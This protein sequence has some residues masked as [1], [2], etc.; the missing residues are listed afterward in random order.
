MPLHFV[1]LKTP[2]KLLL[3]TFSTFSYLFLEKKKNFFFL[4]YLFL[5]V[6]AGNLSKLIFMQ[7]L[8]SRACVEFGLPLSLTR[9]VPR[10][11]DQA[12][13]TFVQTNLIKLKEKKKKL[14]IY[15]GCVSR[16]AFHTRLG[17]GSEGPRPWQAWGSPRAHLRAPERGQTW[18]PSPGAP[19]MPPP[20]AAPQGPCL[21]LNKSQRPQDAAGPA[22]R[23]F[24]PL[25]AYSVGKTGPDPGPR[26]PPRRI[27]EPVSG[28][29]TAFF[30]RWH[31]ARL[32]A[33]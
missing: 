22:A 4:A 18:C 12:T 33:G 30:G 23:V 16:V 8:L 6:G 10:L 31:G 28:W 17:F 11:S 5:G 27:P 19:P 1:H 13:L 29:L 21:D 14:F 15:V 20:P 7:N 2:E 3:F 24:L 32:G 9:S 26:F 25:G